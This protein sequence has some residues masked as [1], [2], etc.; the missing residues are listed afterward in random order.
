M[1]AQLGRGRVS[2]LLDGEVQLARDLYAPPYR[3]CHG[4]ARCIDFEHPLYLLA[5]LFVVG[6]EVEGLLDPLDYQ[7]LTL[8][9]YLPHR[10]GV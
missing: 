2:R 3:A 7:H 10:L 5:I 6:A 1:E 8:G 9:L 4:A